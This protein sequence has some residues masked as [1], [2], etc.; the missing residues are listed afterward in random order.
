MSRASRGD[1]ASVPHKDTSVTRL[2]CHTE[3]AS[4]PCRASMTDRASVSEA[5]VTARAGVR[6]KASVAARAGVRDSSQ[7]WRERQGVTACAG[8]G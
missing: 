4:V 1:R 8:E 3:K 7:G 6:D 2:A 5:S